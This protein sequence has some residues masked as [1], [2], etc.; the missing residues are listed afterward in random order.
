MAKKA[1]SIYTSWEEVNA[2]MKELGE[3][4]VKKQKLEGE[5]TEKINKIKA[6]T[7][8][9]AGAIKTQIAEI[10]KNIERFAMQNKSEFLKTRTKKLTFGTVSF[11]LVESVVCNCKEEALKA[12]KALNLDFLIRSK[13]DL[14]KDE[15]LKYAKSD[16]KLLLKAGISIKAEDKVKIEP[17]F[18]KLM[19]NQ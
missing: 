10:E 14:D 17:D 8:A 5:Q 6:E 12:L 15:C 16:E 2:A 11:R 9:K 19:A 4:N 18:V 3:L 7:L 13:E 1:D